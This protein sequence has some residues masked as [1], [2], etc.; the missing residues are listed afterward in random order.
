VGAEGAAWY[1]AAM[2]PET[3]VQSIVDRIIA[4]AGI[5]PTAAVPPGVEAVRRVGE[6]ATWLFLINHTAYPVTV[7]VSGTDLLDGSR[8]TGRTVVEGGRV[9]V[10]REEAS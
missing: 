1:V 8:H 5:A 9:R 6:G 10:I 7:G 2:L 3:S 4:E